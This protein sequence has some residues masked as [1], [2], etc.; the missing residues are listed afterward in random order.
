MG[1]LIAEDSSSLLMLVQNEQMISKE[2]G[3]VVYDK[4]AGKLH[5]Y[6]FDGFRTAG[7]IKAQGAFVNLL[8][9]EFA[10]FLPLCER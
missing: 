2:N 4:I 10:F 8:Q 9:Q 1:N 6:D 3:D 5:E 7:K